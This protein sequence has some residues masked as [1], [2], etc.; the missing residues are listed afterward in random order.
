MGLC[1]SSGFSEGGWQA[2]CV[3]RAAVLRVELE[4]ASPCLLQTTRP[5]PSIL[6][7]IWWFSAWGGMLNQ[8]LLSRGVTLVMTPDHA[9]LMSSA[10]LGRGSLPWWHRV[11]AT[12]KETWGPGWVWTQWWSANHGWMDVKMTVWKRARVCVHVCTHMDWCVTQGEGL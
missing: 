10:R 12:G 2:A 1:Q 7:L 3:E 5:L 8:E 6:F 9:H 11:Q 4:E